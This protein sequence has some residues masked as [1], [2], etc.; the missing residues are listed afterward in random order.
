MYFK[1]VS[2]REFVC[3]TGLVTGLGFLTHIA[4]S[5]GGSVDRILKPNNYSITLSTDFVNGGGDVEI[6]ES[7]PVVIK[8]RPH[9]EGDGGWS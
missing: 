1:K 8:I 6:V 3:K 5:Y 2:R 4:E 7:D 9:N